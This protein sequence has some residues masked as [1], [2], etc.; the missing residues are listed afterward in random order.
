M[1]LDL[2]RD[3]ENSSANR[4][5]ATKRA[6]RAIID[7]DAIA[8]NVKAFRSLVSQSTLLMAVVKANG[9]GHGAVMVART[10]IEAGADQLAVATVDEGIQLRTAGIDLPI[11]LLGPIALEEYAAATRS[12]LQI[13]VGSLEQIDAAR[14]A[15]NSIDVATALKLHLKI[16]TGMRRY[17]CMP[18]DAKE[19]ARLI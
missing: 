2:S 4:T 13:S 11:L 3:I 7:L 8:E 10:A 12:R 1:K 6:T 16:D 19:L 9:Y 18:E 5:A 17:G 14:L 15:A